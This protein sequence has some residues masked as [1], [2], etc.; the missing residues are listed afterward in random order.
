MTVHRK[1]DKLTINAPILGILPVKDC[2]WLVT[3]V[4]CMSVEGLMRIGL[5][6]LRSYET[7]PKEK[8][9]TG[10]NGPALAC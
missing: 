9:K 1:W 2:R 3:G 10:H 5:T 7:R 4:E 8:Q 6:T